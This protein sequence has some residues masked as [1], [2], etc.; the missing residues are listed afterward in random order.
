MKKI[1][2]IMSLIVNVFL[3]IAVLG[4]RLHYHKMIFQTLYNVTTSEVRFHESI[5]VELQSENEYKINAVKT[6]LEKNIQDEKEFTA[7]WKA[8]SE[9]IGLK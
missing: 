6:M 9:R 4:I 7:I 1:P 8:A 2:L 3:A 5:L